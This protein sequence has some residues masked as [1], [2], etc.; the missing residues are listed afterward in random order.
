MQA[1]AQ[2]AASLRWLHDLPDLIEELERE[3][4]VDAQIEAI[5]ATLRQARVP[6]PEG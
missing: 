1:A 2:G 4:E 5:S 6:A 3:W